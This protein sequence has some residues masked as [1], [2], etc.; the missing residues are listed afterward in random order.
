MAKYEWKVFD[1]AKINKIS[2]VDIISDQKQFSEIIYKDV[3]YPIECV[4]NSDGTCV[5][6]RCGSE[7]QFMGS[8]NMMITT[9]D[10]IVDENPQWTIIVETEKIRFVVMVTIY[11]TKLGEFTNIMDQYDT[12]EANEHGYQEVYKTEKQ[13][14]FVSCIYN[15]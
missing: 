2:V 10:Q 12:L 1:L 7:N 3:R 13:L 9:F 15:N 14:K 5:E 4:F 6:S 8:K 11:H